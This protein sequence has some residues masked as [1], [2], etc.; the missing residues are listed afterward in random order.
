[1]PVALKYPGVYIQ[2]LA[3]DVRTIMGV[4][5]ADTAFIGSAARGPV[6]DAR[7]IHSFA[8]YTAIFGGLSLLS[9]MS[10]AVQQFFL[11]GGA[12]AI[13]VRVHKNATPAT[14]KLPTAT[15][16][17]VLEAANPGTWGRKLTAAIDYKTSDLADINLYNLT[18]IDTASGAVEV[19][20][21]LSSAA[22][23]LR[24]I[25]DVLEN[26]SKLARVKTPTPNDRPTDTPAATPVEADDTTG[27]D[28][29]AVTDSQIT[30]TPKEGLNALDKVD[31]FN[32]L[33]IPPYHYD[34][35]LP[36]ADPGSIALTAALAYCEKRR[37]VLIV[38]P[39]ANWEETADP[40]DSTLGVDGTP[41]IGIARSANACL[42]FPRIIALDPLQEG[43]QQAYA[44]CGLMAGIMARTDA[45]RGVW[46][47]PAGIEATLSGV[48]DLS[49]RLTDDEIG[50]LNPIGVNC[51][52]QMEGV[53]RVA[54]GART[55][56][57][58]DRLT[59]QWKY[60]PVRRLAL[61]IEESLFR[62]TQWVVFEPN[63]EPLW[64]QIRLN[65][66]AFMHTLYRQGAFQGTSPR[67]AYFVK[68]D[69]QTTTDDDR[70]RGVVNILVGFAPLKPAEFVVISLQQM[71]G[72]VQT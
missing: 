46:K 51:L 36:N 17:I 57:G 25:E 29:L 39:P 70:N 19:F 23:A 16:D 63:D 49:V 21:N 12:T 2:E 38:D 13:I 33:C 67:E 27:S 55:M 69:A 28:G 34:D 60:L 14:L 4:P 6:N 10:Y 30:G 47:A 52:R 11:N 61:F 3:S 68:C 45:S 48:V 9:P 64:A 22:G 41:G 54:W 18:L 56:R 20:R 35:S 43:R 59:D 8:E 72:Q 53:G 24:R 44:P 65:V 50:E 26:S 1:M 71:A 5:T 58:A 62:G 15:A 7:M 66:G 32:L 40:Q 31:I 37:A 42:Y